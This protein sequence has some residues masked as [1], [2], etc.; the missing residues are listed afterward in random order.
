LNLAL[1]L[2]PQITAEHHGTREPVCSQRIDHYPLDEFLSANVPANPLSCSY[3]TMASFVADADD[4][5]QHL[6]NVEDSN[7]VTVF[8]SA[9]KEG[10]VSPSH[11]GRVQLFA[12]TPT[13]EEHSGLTQEVS[14]VAVGAGQAD[15][16]EA[17]EQAPVAAQEQE[18]EETEEQRVERET[19][20][21]EQYAWELMRSEAQETYRAQME[22]MEANAHLMS[23]ED[24]AALQAAVAESV[25]PALL[26][27][28]LPAGEGAGNAGEEEE[29]EQDDDEAWADPNNYDRLLQLGA[30]LG[31]VKKDRWRRAA[32]AIIAALPEMTYSAVQSMQQ[33]QQ[34][35]EPASP[36]ISTA[37]GS[38]SKEASPPY[39][40]KRQ[41]CPEDKEEKEE[42]QILKYTDTRCAVC[43]EPFEAAAL[44]R[45]LPCTHYFH[46]ECAVGWVR[47]HNS[48]P[49]CLG[50]VVP[51]PAAK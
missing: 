33:R 46:S 49:C 4:L 24:L 41:R 8:A 25:D 5:S 6:E 28:A 13:D 38:G 12:S 29:E 31:D 42:E 50:K 40:D 32:D 30:E 47:G 15:E 44:L 48:C 39:P 51:S 16:G 37:A 43:M 23:A 9:A 17:P 45:L 21:S 1:S 14:A 26:A 36:S 11:V 34:Q 2:E 35:G 19:R 20:E 10:P 3:R 27:A 7:V 18:E 22:F